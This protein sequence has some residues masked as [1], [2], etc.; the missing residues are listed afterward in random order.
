MGALHNMRARAAS[1]P[2]RPWCE[3]TCSS[4]S[5]P[6]SPSGLL[7]A[8]EESRHGDDG[9]ANWGADGCGAREIGVV[10]VR[11]HP[12]SLRGGA[13]RGGR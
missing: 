1:S 4:V 13:A 12:R 7:L 5:S 2:V 10:A 9:G 6:R 11:A 8:G 3:A